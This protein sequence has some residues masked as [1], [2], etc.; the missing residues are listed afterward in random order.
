MDDF[1][2]VESVLKVEADPP[3]WTCFTSDRNERIM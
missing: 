2:S 1:N 3:G